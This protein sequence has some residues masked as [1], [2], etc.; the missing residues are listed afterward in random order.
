MGN[1]GGRPCKWSLEIAMRFAHA[2]GQ[3]RS[4]DDAAR[5]AGVVPST[6]W[7]WVQAGR[8]GDPRFR[9]LVRMVEAGPIKAYGDPEQ[10]APST[11]A[12][13]KQ[14]QARQDPIHLRAG[15]VDPAP[16]GIPAD[17]VAAGAPGLSR[18]VY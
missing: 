8:N 5:A 13:I 4:L 9:E 16:N 1:K 18:R 7:R 15:G 6:A 17:D 2:L 3:A 11:R 14:L 10:L 12:W